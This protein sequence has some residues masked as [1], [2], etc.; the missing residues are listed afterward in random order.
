MTK[1]LRCARATDEYGINRLAGRKA[2]AS[3]ALERKATARYVRCVG[4]F[5][6]AWVRGMAEAATLTAKRRGQFQAAMARI[7]GEGRT[8]LVR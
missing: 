6:R 4:R 7:D 5:A 3:I 2:V 8:I 1:K